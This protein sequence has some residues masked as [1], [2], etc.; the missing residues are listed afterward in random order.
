MNT[1]IDALASIIRKKIQERLPELQATWKTSSPVLHVVID[2]LLP[3]DLAGQIAPGFPD[4]SSMK[5]VDNLR[6]K[7]FTCATRSSWAEL[8]G[9]AFL[10]LQ[11]PSVLEALSAITGINNLTGDPSAYAG[12]LSAMST[13]CF[14]NP[15]LDNST[16]PSI[17]GYRR[18]N[19]L[20]Y[21]SQDWT[22]ACGGNLELWS[23]RM[24]ER[25]EVTSKFNRLV[26]M[27]T[28]RLSLHAVNK[29]IAKDYVR[30]CLSNYYFTVEKNGCKSPINSV[31]AEVLPLPVAGYNYNFIKERMS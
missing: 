19:A 13:G 24:T 27:N 16:H 30:R 2:N 5:F 9:N 20:Y 1:S 7:K 31:L 14:L 15:H 22:T 11:H 29:V 17:D 26:I 28:N 6:E 12:G 4:I 10:A 21:C 23:P 3:D 18:L 25:L 8:T